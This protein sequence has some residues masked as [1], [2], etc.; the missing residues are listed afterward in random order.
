MAYHMERE[1]NS[2]DLKD[3]GRCVIEGGGAE[4][5]RAQKEEHGGGKAVHLR[6]VIL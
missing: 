5:R 2:T 6:G 1:D 4:G 3:L